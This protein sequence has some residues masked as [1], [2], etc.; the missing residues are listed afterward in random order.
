MSEYY[1]RQGNPISVEESHRLI[2]E[3]SARGED[4][5]RVSRTEIPG[6]HKDISVSTVW[7]GLDHS[8]GDTG[9]LIF[10][11]MVF[12]GRFDGECER[13]ETEEDAVE[14]HDRM[15][16]LISEEQDAYRL[17]VKNID[18][19]RAVDVI[20]KFV[21]EHSLKYFIDR[22]IVLAHLVAEIDKR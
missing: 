19:Q 18:I 21:G 5:K 20:G 22:D 10:E 14:G 4:Y 1:D 9:P 7:L 16:K 11:T 12:G 2:K 8:F 17:L 15:V 3:A 6:E 13:Y